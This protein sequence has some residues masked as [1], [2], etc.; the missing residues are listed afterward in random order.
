MS[1][2]GSTAMLPTRLFEG[3]RVLVFGVANERSI[4]W[5]MAEAMH[6]HGAELI[7]TYAADLLE[8][9]VRPLAEGLGSPLVLP[10]DVTDDAQVD[11][12]FR[13]VADVW[14]SFDVLIHAVAFA[15]RGVVYAPA[16]RDVPAE[17]QE[18]WRENLVAFRERLHEIGFFCNGVCVSDDA[19]AHL[20]DAEVGVGEGD[21]FST[22]VSLDFGRLVV[23]AAKN[24]DRPT[25]PLKITR[26]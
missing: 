24:A 1:E 20:I 14:D 22:T 26:Y 4:A 10:C 6:Q 7:F 19:I 18:P 8:K 21:R 16:H 25:C 13:R 5:S 12:C 9:R 15:N 17:E 11:E 3:K 23:K 2:E